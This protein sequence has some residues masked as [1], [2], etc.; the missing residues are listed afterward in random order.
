MRIL[1]F[2]VVE[3]L[4]LESQLD[5]EEEKEWKD[6]RLHDYKEDSKPH[7]VYRWHR[8]QLRHLFRRFGFGKLV[9]FPRRKMIFV[10]NREE[11]LVDDCWTFRLVTAVETV[12]ASMKE[13]VF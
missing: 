2:S 7:F 13:V 5:Q 3:K 4:E 8:G 9:Y 10:S 1:R 12:F 6:R 11:A